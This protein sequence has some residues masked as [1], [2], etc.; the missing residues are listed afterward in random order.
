MICPV[1]FKMWPD[2]HLPVFLYALDKVCYTRSTVSNEEEEGLMLNHVVLMK[3]KPGVAENKIAKLEELMD[4][5]PNTISEI[6]V[7]EFGRNTVPS[8]RAYD[9]ALVSLFANPESLERYRQHP[10]HLK[11]LDLI[12]DICENF[13][14]TD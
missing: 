12:K 8:E 14:S 6:L 10:D 3:F 4:N 1:V 5:L 13:I 9:F 11:V 7:Y 2:S